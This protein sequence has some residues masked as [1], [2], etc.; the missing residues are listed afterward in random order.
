MYWIFKLENTEFN[1]DLKE[2]LDNFI[3]KFEQKRNFSGQIGDHVIFLINNIDWLFT[4]YGKIALIKKDENQ[5]PEGNKWTFSVSFDELVEIKEPRLLSDLSY[6]LLKIHKWYNIPIRHIRGQYC[7]IEK[8]D[9]YTIIN[10][11]IFISRTAFGKIVN[12]LHKD[13]RI[14][15]L[16]MLLEENPSLYTRGGDYLK[17]F[18][19]LKEYIDSNLNPHIRMLSEIGGLLR[20]ISPEASEK[21]AFAEPNNI[22]T[23]NF[24]IS[25]QVNICDEFISSEIG[26]NYMEVLFQEI[27]KVYEEEYEFG[28]TFINKPLP[29]YLY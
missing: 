6:S 24:N 16:Q 19:V 11:Q 26:I 21:L 29:I 14:F 13:H 3:F 15:F 22:E 28:R 2:N 25:E 10:G 9:Y 5:I 7:R 27:S 18:Q 12:S 23:I 20:E 1:R 17:I 8:S 4:Y